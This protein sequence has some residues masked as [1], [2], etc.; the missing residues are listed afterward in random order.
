MCPPYLYK[1]T[2]NLLNQK[3]NFNK[4]VFQIAIGIVLDLLLCIR[5]L[6]CI[7]PDLG[8]APMKVQFPIL[9][10]VMCLIVQS[11]TTFS[12]I[13]ELQKNYGGS[14]NDVANSITRTS[15]NGLVVAGSSIS[16]DGDVSGNHGGYDYWVIKT[17]SN[18][19]L[20]W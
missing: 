17:D 11:K 7:Y 13:F 3:E 12:Q 5:Y 19:V 1:Y 8:G 14:G 20:Q 10:I 15:D 6:C 18:G 4:I 9:I 16:T 2:P